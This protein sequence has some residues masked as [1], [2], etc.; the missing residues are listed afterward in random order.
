MIMTDKCSDGRAEVRFAEEHHALQALGL[1]GL[2]KP[3]G[4]CVQIGTPRRQD[5]WRYATVTKC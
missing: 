4:K 3:G 5:Q 2:D 1:G